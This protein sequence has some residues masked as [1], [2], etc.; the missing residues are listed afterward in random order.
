ME[1]NNPKTQA[2]TLQDEAQNIK[3]QINKRTIAI[4]AVI[5]VVIAIVVCGIILVRNNGSNKADEAVALADLEMNDSIKLAR[6][7]DAAQ[8]GYKSGNRA[9]LNAA[10]QLYKKGEYQEAIKYLDDAS[11]SSSIIDAGRLSLMG[12]CY[13]NLQDY[14]KALSCYNKAISAADGNPQIVPFILIKEANIYREQ[15]NY[16]NEYDAYLKVTKEYP[17]YANAVRGDLTK[18]VERARI[19]AGK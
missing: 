19:Q 11:I 3:N 1:T 12:D 9:K 13:V 4:V 10:I 17:E 18:Y 15:G 6:Y 5:V 2:Q 14:D 7:I 8:M 16:A